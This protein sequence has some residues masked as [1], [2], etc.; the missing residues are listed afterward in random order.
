M[1][2]A[3]ASTYY[4]KDVAGNM[5]IYNDCT[6]LTDKLRSLAEKNRSSRLKLE[7]DINALESLRKRSYGKEMESQRTIIRDLLDGAQGFTNCSVS[8]FAAECENAVTMTVDRIRDVERQWN[9][10]L[11]R[12]A[13]LQSIGQLLSTAISKI[14]IDIQDM[15]DISESDSHRLRKFCNQVAELKDLF[16]EDERDMTGVYTPQWFKFQYLS[17]I[18]ESSLA[19]IKFLWIEGELR[20]EFEVEEVIDLIEALFAESEHRR[21]A[22]TEIKRS[23]GL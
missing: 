20:L 4:A 19:D 10:V 7:S 9:G 22:I 12:S 2:R 15:S 23:V 3:T 16:Q 5:L 18:L 13:L 11:S 17:E 8:P 14:C 21:R 1:F 6:H